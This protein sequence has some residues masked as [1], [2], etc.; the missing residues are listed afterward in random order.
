MNIVF[1][2]Y[3]SVLI[4]FTLFVFQ[5]TYTQT[6]K[7]KIGLLLAD[8][9]IERWAKD[10][11]YFLSKSDELNYTTIVCDAKNNQLLQNHQ[12]DSLIKEGIKI[13]IVVPVDGFGAAILVDSAHSK[14]VKVLAYDRLIMNCNLDA[15]ISYDNELIGRIMV[16][17]ATLNFKKGTVAYIG[18]PKSDMNSI[19]I[20]KGVLR[21]LKP[22][23]KNN[24][25]HL[26]CDTFTNH[27]SSIE[28]TK[29]LKEYL[30]VNKCPD[31]IFAAN[32]ELAKGIII[33]LDSIGLA[34]K[35]IV[36][37]QDAD[38]NACQN[39]ISGKQ[40]LTIFKPIRVLAERAVQLSSG[41]LGDIPFL[42]ISEV[43]NG[44]VNVPSFILAPLPV[45]KKNLRVSVI[46][47]GYHTEDQIFRPK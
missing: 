16:I 29:I 46:R 32:D 4:I 15:Y 33:V 39:L 27:W 6:S 35:V 3:G 7:T 2:Y 37:G 10:R 5:N 13:L 43:N 19:A 12:A 24:S 8:L 30:L 20:H 23:L 11:D 17:Y 45:D 42:T 38:L 9:T 25:M 36:T 1:K 31:A 18:G 47:E 22:Y 21:E 34:G 28:S 26:V 14:G 41:L 44:K 40:T